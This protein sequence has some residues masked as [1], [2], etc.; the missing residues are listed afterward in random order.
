MQLYREPN[1][2]F[3]RQETRPSAAHGNRQKSSLLEPWTA[4]FV[5][6]EISSNDGPGGDGPSHAAALPSMPEAPAVAFLSPPSDRWANRRVISMYCY[7]AA[8]VRRRG[9][10]HPLTAI[11]AQAPTS[12]AKGCA[13]IGEILQMLARGA[14]DRLRNLLPHKAIAQAQGAAGRPD[15]PRNEPGQ[16]DY[17][18]RYLKAEKFTI[19]EEAAQRPSKLDTFKPSVVQMLQSYLYSAAQG[20]A[21]SSGGGVRRGLHRGQGV[22]RKVCP[23]R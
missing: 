14:R 12:A 17:E 7:P 19:L 13:P 15:R 1:T 16:E 21:A 11:L 18:E 2:W 20:S 4:Y 8:S 22:V 5:R 10:H 3:S 23:K 9:S 6:S